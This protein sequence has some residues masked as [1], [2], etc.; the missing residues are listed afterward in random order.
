MRFLVLSF[1]FLVA[2]PICNSQV[3]FTNIINGKNTKPE[4]LNLFKFSN[5]RDYAMNKWGTEIY[6]SVQSP[7][8]EISAIVWSKKKKDKWSKP[9]V[10]SFSG[11]FNDLEP[12][13]SWDNTRLYF[14][15]NR[16][17]DKKS[18]STKDFD[19]WYC[20]RNPAGYWGEPKNLGAPVNTSENEFYP[21]VSKSGNLYF[22]NDGKRSKGKDDIFVCKFTDGKYCSP[23]SVSDSINTEG[24]EFNSFVGPDE[25]YIIFTGYNKPDGMGGGD[26]YV[27]YHKKD[28]N[29][30]QAKNMGEAFNSKFMDYCPFVDES[31]KTLYFTSK[32]SNTNAEFEKNLTTEELLDAINVY[33]NG[34]SRLYKVSLGDWLKK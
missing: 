30:T 10:L 11:K 8:S 28:G 19:I 27:S 26:L 9:K 14:V 18:N 32:R 6:F 3:N 31:T 4:E 17:L 34:Q 7:S 16:P 22:T 23:I 2:L 12:F 33:A 21:S 25:D 1:W 5:V 20:E 15:S 24:Y 29:W 13:L